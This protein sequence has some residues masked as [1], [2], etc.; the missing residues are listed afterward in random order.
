[1]KNLKLGVKI[2]LG[3]GI[4][5]LIAGL[6]GGMAMVNML[7]VGRQAERL[8]Q[9]V[10]PEV[11]VAT[12]V[13]R[14]SLQTMFAM[15]GFVY[16]GDEAFWKE[17]QKELV[18]VDK[19]L[20]QARELARKYP[21]LVKLKE[22]ADKASTK[23]AEWKK[24]AEQSYALEHAM[25]ANRKTMD[26]SAQV[27]MKNCVMYLE[28]QQKALFELLGNPTAE[29]AKIKDRADKINII[30]DVIDAGNAVRVANFKGQAHRDLK[31][32]QDGL[33]N[34]EIIAAKEQQLRAITRLEAN[35]RQL[36][37][38]RKAG[39]AYKEAML[40]YVKNSLASEEATKTR[41][42]VAEDVLKAASDTSSYGV[43]LTEQLTDEASKSLSASSTIMA[44]GLVIA[45]IMGVAV[46]FFITK[47]ITGPVIQG[48][49][50][51]QKM[52]EGDMTL[53]LQ[54]NQK[55]EIGM[56]ADAL[57]EMTRRL[58][59]VMGEVVEGANNVASGAQELSATSESLSQGASEQAASVEEVSSSMEEMT[60][61]IQQNADNSVQTESMA[62]KAARDAE[63]GGRAVSQ[64]V[65]A[66][67][68]IAEKISIIEEIARQTNLLALNAAIEA[69]RAGEHGK[70]FAVV[71][72]EVRKLAERSGHAA[73]EISSLSTESVAVAEKAGNMLSAIVPDIKKTAELVQEIAAGSRE[74]SAGADQI[75]KAIQQL[76]QVIQQNAS[77]SEEMASTSE[78]LS[79]QAEQLLSTVSFFK[80]K[81]SHHGSRPAAPKAL[82]HGTSSVGRPRPAARKG[83]K[84]GKGV[85]IDLGAADHDNDF[86]KF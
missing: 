58:N 84:P 22:N 69:A 56:L 59:E 42:L 65:G 83:A 51:A 73:A 6:L 53:D 31:I 3:F 47:G 44:V 70:G 18:D 30:N 75:N 48:V 52:S 60:S 61:N 39:E 79:S 82:P 27:F 35:I 21:N 76:D 68:Q 9:E 54:V 2:G 46:A 8:A 23:V 7:S 12:E 10:A 29:S 80:L 55:D 4:L 14:S 36:N 32:I 57:R 34:F 15:R 19:A 63:E 71:A 43:K 20:Q 50:F 62:M 85:S 77:A 64:T 49:T 5:I 26:E 45:L 37:D 72:A 74:Q 25:D 40:A 24:L 78:E 28:S 13:E 11:S 41:N 1:M 16:T 17:T 38:I 33:K 81:G 66:M 86:E 67:K